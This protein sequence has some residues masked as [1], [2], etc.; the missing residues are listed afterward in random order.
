MTNA[1]PTPDR[2]QQAVQ[3][4]ISRIRV[5]ETNL[6]ITAA[7]RD[8]AQSKIAELASSL[9]IL[10]QEYEVLQNHLIKLRDEVAEVKTSA[11]AE[12]AEL[13]AALPVPE[14]TDRH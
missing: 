7:Q 9:E 13:K 3:N 6:K 2:Q 5:L 11:E 4:M 1:T 14:A 12:I 8:A 10:S